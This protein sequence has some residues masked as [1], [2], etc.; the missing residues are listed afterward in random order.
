MCDL[1]GSIS[2]SCGHYQVESIQLCLDVK[3]SGIMDCLKQSLDLRKELYNH[4][5]RNTTA[6]CLDCVGKSVGT[7]IQPRTEPHFPHS[8]NPYFQC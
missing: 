2:S 6:K 7:G 8:N 1:H 4:T 5:A 3:I